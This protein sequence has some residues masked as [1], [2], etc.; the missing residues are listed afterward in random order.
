MTI[1]ELAEFTGK[2]K[3][4]ISRWCAKCTSPRIS[5]Q[6]QNATGDK[7]ADFS[8]DEVEEIL[9]AGS[10]SKDAVA[11]L[12]LNARHSNKSLITEDTLSSAMALMAK[13]IS[14]LADKVSAMSGH[15]PQEPKQLQLIPPKS[16]R[17]K[18]NQAVRKHAED[19][20]DGDYR[21]AW[22]RLYSEFYYRM[23]MNIRI[24]AE[25]AGM[26]KVEY[27]ETEGLIDTAIEL[28]REPEEA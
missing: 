1:K 24:R 27:L 3:S 14:I 19:Y 22:K 23:S 10:L 25:H 11:I 26:S 17:A 6:L 18:L 20:H 4:T 8:I 5:D 16:D 28:L 12:M 15:T 21:S 9:I 7:P 2:N 13:S